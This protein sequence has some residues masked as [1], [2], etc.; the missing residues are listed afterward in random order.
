VQLE[1]KGPR[2]CCVEDP[3]WSPKDINREV[4]VRTEEGT[5]CFLTKKSRGTEL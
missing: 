2:Q 3:P 5:F 1:K 4:K